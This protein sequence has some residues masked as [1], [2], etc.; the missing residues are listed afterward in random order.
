MKDRTLPATKRQTWVLYTL[1]KLDYRDKNLTIDEADQL[2]KSLNAEKNGSPDY[3]KPTAKTEKI[4]TEL[5][6]FLCSNAEKLLKVFEDETNLKSIISDDPMTTTKPKKYVFVGGGCGFSHII[7]DK[8]SKKAQAILTEFRSCQN[9]FIKWFIEN[10]IP[11]ETQDELNFLGAPVQ[12]ILHQN[13]SFNSTLS[14]IVV[15]YMA[16]KGIENV[17]VNNFYD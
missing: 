15:K 17:K 2:I 9:Q 10:H 4:A 6:D 1:T 12:A 5:F 8:R 7:I 14:N 16:T 13:L 11:K 3:K